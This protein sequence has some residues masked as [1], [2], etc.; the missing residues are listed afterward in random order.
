MMMSSSLKK[1]EKDCG[2]SCS[3]TPSE[4]SSLDD[5]KDGSDSDYESDHGQDRFDHS[6]VF[7]IFL[8]TVVVG[9]IDTNSVPLL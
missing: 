1:S 6:Y 8:E 4:H 7:S 9:F 5:D 3:M 2:S